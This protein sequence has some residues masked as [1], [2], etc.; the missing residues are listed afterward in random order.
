M[1]NINY[2]GIGV[3]LLYIEDLAGFV[4]SSIPNDSNG[5]RQVK[6]HALVSSPIG[7]TISANGSVEFNTIGIADFINDLTIDTVSQFDRNEPIPIDVGQ[8]ALAATNLAIAINSF[9]PASGPNYKA[10]AVGKKVFLQAPK[11]A[12][13]TVNGDVV[14]ITVG[15]PASQTITEVDVDGGSTGEGLISTVTGY[16]YYLNPTTD[17]INGDIAS[18]GTEEISEFII[19][20]GT[21][22]QIPSITQQI[23]LESLVDLDRYSQ[24]QVLEMEAAGVTGLKTI[25]GN[26]ATHDILIVKNTSSFVTTLKEESDGNIKLS[27]GLDFAMVNDDYLIWLIYVDDPTDG[28]VWRELYRNP[29][30]IG[31]DSIT[32]VELAN[33]SVGTPELKDLS[34]TAIKI[35]LNTITQ[36]Q[37]GLLSVGTPELIDSSVTTIKLDDLS[38]TQAKLALLS[39]GTAQ[40]IDGSVTEDK[41]ANGSVTTDK[42][43]A[44]YKKGSFTMPISWETGELG[45]VKRKIPYDMTV[46]SIF[47][48]VS[49]G[50]EATDDATVIF[51]NNAGTS[52]TGAQIDVPAGDPVGNDFTSTPSANNTFIADEVMQFETLK[53]NPGGKA[54][55]TVCYTRP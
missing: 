46:D 22:Q 52:M 54:V 28:L 5:V 40:L 29:L 7:Y 25:T 37:M 35:A 42:L 3:G 45:I 21:Q 31:A 1:S 27:G 51:K 44:D 9:T 39:V 41:L 55:V 17:A 18:P 53:P 32:D 24:I 43:S 6:D 36:A 15:I 26:F 13:E 8:E 16:K 33:L 49:K 11:S 48:S 38:V 47:L 12:G 34:V 4:V 14:L 10:V 23:A 19:G 2:L 20:R 30:T 50:I